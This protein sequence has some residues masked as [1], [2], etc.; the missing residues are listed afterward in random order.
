MPK[1]RVSF[2]RLTFLVTL[3]L[4]LVFSVSIALAQDGGEGDDHGGDHAVHWSY[5]GMEGPEYW[6]ELNTDYTF[7]GT[8][9]TQSPIGISGVDTP[10]EGSLVFNWLPTTLNIVN[11]GHAIQLDYDPGSS[12]ELDGK[13]YNLLQF[14]F[15]MGSENTID[16]VQFP[17]EVHFVHQSEDGELAVIGVMLDLGEEDNE[18][19]QTFWAHLPTLVTERRTIPAI[20]VDA[21]ELLP[22]A[23]SYY[24]FMGSLTTPPCSEGVNWVVM[25]EPVYLSQAQLDAFAAIY[26]HNFR[27]TQPLNDRV[28]TLNE[29]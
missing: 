28:V 22:E 8:G 7:C 12:V 9:M 20:E 4:L 5:D 11:N 19:Y 15:H 3:I 26:D 21:N 10:D 6:G 25:A 17:M 16:G 27:P 24:R 1:P 2:F 13:A 14:H 23:H 29:G 18:A